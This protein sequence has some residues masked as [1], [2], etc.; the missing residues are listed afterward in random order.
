VLGA[1][2]NT[3]P[4]PFIGFEG[5]FAAAKKRGKGEKR[6]KERTESDGRDRR[7]ILPEINFWLRFCCM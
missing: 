7:K 3:Y 1:G 4:N 2:N 6:R 5:H